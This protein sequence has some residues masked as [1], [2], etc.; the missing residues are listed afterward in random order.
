MPKAK[1]EQR[2]YQRPAEI[3]NNAIRVGRYQL[4]GLLGNFLLEETERKNQHPKY[5]G[6][7]TSKNIWGA[8]DYN[9]WQNNQH[10]AGPTGHQEKEKYSSV[11]CQSSVSIKRPI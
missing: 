10:Y 11:I 2:A 6:S 8:C 3:L 9:N 4:G 5:W 7:K 1:E